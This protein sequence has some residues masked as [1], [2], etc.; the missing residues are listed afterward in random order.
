[1]ASR[2]ALPQQKDFAL[3]VW[4]STPTCF[5]PRVAAREG[6]IRAASIALTAR[7]RARKRGSMTLRCLKAG[8]LTAGSALTLALA[9]SPVQSPPQPPAAS[10]AAASAPASGAS[11]TA[12]PG[13][14][15]GQVLALMPRGLTT[16][17]AATHRGALYVLGGY[18]G[19]P[20]AYSN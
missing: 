14:L 1:M 11:E 16:F 20:H 7:P 9:C 3:S 2:T 6:G 13:S 12:L 8:T 15:N 10:A 5:L 17:G 19:T 4:E 18:F